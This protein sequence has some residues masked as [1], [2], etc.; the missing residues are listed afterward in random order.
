MP[1]LTLW[2]IQRSFGRSSIAPESLAGQKITAK[3][4]QQ[5]G[6]TPFSEALQGRM[7]KM[8]LLSK[9]IS[10]APSN[11]VPQTSQREDLDQK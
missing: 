10:S 5:S 9:V 1:L 7:E 3:D 2:R 11:Q 8:L 6:R 4:G